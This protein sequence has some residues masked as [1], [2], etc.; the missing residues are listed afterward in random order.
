MQAATIWVVILGTA[1]ASTLKEDDGSLLGLD[2]ECVVPGSE[3]CSISVLQRKARADE[4]H[5]AMPG[6]SCYDEIQW[7]KKTGVHEHPHWYPGLTAASSDA[8]FQVIVHFKAPERKCSLPC[9]LHA[10]A[11]H[12]ALP[13]EACHDDVSWAKT[14][15]IHQHPSWYRG[16]T[17]HSSDAAFQ[18]QLHIKGHNTKCTAMPCSLFKV[19]AEASTAPMTTETTTTTTTTE[20]VEVPIATA[21]PTQLPE[22][23]NQVQPHSEP[24]APAVGETSEQQ[25]AREARDRARAVQEQKAREARERAEHAA[26][27]EIPLD[28]MHDKIIAE[29][30]GEP[31]NDELPDDVTDED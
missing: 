12:D 28:V 14:H 13:G 17:P 27:R 15:G 6:E 24:G 23:P 7:A 22:A 10:H 2:D 26:R 19:Q 20:L 8:E 9:T 3:A 30:G 5:D 25:A 31:L 18:A 4:C 1:L 21:A 16:L 29:I 11:C